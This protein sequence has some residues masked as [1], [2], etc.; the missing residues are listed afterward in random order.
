MKSN[1]TQRDSENRNNDKWQVLFGFCGP[2]SHNSPMSR[3]AVFTNSQKKTKNLSKVCQ[4]SDKEA[5]F[6]SSP[7]YFAD[8]GR[9]ASRRNSPSLVQLEHQF[10]HTAQECIAHL[11]CVAASPFYIMVFS[12][13][14]FPN[15]ATLTVLLICE[16]SQPAVRVGM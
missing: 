2:H 3:F 11:K 16:T 8:C 10:V 14:L 9:L 12:V 1:S 7:L 5:A 13:R 4:H 6:F 15:A